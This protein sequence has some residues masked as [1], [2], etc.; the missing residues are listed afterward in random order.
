MFLASVAVVEFASVGSMVAV[1]VLFVPHD[2]IAS[3]RSLTICSS[4]V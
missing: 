3:S 2:S 4:V 1:A